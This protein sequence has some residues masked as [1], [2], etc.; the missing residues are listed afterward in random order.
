MIILPF[1]NMVFHIDGFVS[2]EP[3]LCPWNKTSLIMVNDP[4]Y[5]LLNSLFCY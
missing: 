4:F 1:A 2:I 5:I 3:S